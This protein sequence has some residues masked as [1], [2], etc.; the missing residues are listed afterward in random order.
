LCKQKADGW[1]SRNGQWTIE[2]IDAEIARLTR[3]LFS[4]QAM[5]A[6]ATADPPTYPAIAPTAPGST[7]RDDTALKTAYTTVYTN[8][9]LVNKYKTN[10]RSAEDD[11]AREAI[12]KDAAYSKAKT[13]LETSQAAL[14]KV[15]SDNTDYHAAQA[16]FDIA[17]LSGMFGCVWSITA[18]LTCT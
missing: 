11:A 16:K 12:E 13:D 2:Q 1:F 3:L 6:L 8:Y 7:G 17:T 18:T 4:Y 15:I 10:I 5:E 14:N 9:A